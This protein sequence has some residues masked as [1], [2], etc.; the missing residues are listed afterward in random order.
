MP[1]Q[2]YDFIH[3]EKDGMKICL[4]FPK[5]AV[6]DE[7]LRREIKAILCCS[8]REQIEKNAFSAVQPACGKEEVF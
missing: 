2:T 4:E 5:Q 3:T 6:R 1:D 7:N 8:L